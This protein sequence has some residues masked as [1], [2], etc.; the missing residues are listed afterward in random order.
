MGSFYTSATVR[1]VRTTDVI[2]AMRGRHAFVA[3]IGDDVAVFDADCER[4]DPR[5]QTALGAHLSQV[6]HRPVLSVLNHDDSVLQLRLHQDGTC[7]L[8]YDSS[9]GYFSGADL[10]PSR[11]DANVLCDALGATDAAARVGEILNADDDAFV[12]ASE[13]HEALHV[14]LG[15]PTPAVGYGFTYLASGDLPPGLDSSD[16][17]EVGGS[18]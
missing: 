16:L 13:R 3:A 5:A 15:L 8:E 6:L 4:Q 7:V 12:F 9:P 2:R 17:V 10:P 1:G 11:V 18:V 14:A